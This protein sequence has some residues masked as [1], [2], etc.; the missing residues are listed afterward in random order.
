MKKDFNLKKIFNKFS[1]AVLL[2]AGIAASPTPASDLS[3]PVQ[4]A[5]TCAAFPDFKKPETPM[6][7]ISRD[8][9]PDPVIKEQ[10]TLLRT[11]DLPLGRPDGKPGPGTRHAMREFLLFYGPLYG[12]KDY[13][14]T[15]DEKDATE[16][17]RIVEQA[18]IDSKKYALPVSTMAALRLAAERTNT[19]L[20]KLTSV[21]RDNDGSL[22]GL[23]AAGASNG[24]FRIGHAPWLALVKIYG[25]QYGMEFYVAHI[26]LEKGAHG[27]SPTV[28][29]PFIHR[30]I[31]ALKSNPRLAALL[32]AEYLSQADSFP[33]LAKPPALAFQSKIKEEQNALMTLGFD[34]GGS[35]ADGLRG[36]MT[37]IALRE[38]QLLYG[39]E[40]TPNG[41]LSKEERALLLHSAQQAR[42]DA[43][44]FNVPAA[45]VGAIRMASQKNE[46]DFGY[47]MELAAAESSFSHAIKASSS[48]AT[49]LYQFIEST[50][51][52]T[53]QDYGH[54][55]GLAD[56]STEVDVYM[57]DYGRSQARINNPLL[58]GQVL[59]MRKNP[60][61]SALLST[62]FQIENRG[63]QSCYIEGDLSRTDMYLAHFLGAHDAVYFINVLR[64]D[65]NKSA[66]KIFPEAAEYNISVFYQK[67]GRQ[68]SRERS[69]GEVYNFFSAKFDKGIYDGPA[70]SHPPAVANAPE[71]PAKAKPRIAR[72]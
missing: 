34:I 10:Q 9:A 45:A 27:I 15:L 68:S 47:M 48:S 30:Q 21:I 41:L 56:F 44:R 67:E 53:L 26:T 6:H 19:D 38:F 2:S 36:T 16:L 46:F 66:V 28:A 71:T 13:Q 59:E 7:R 4:P 37:Q 35:T 69:L 8:I 50:W 32:V 5:N 58:R 49:G 40:G 57:D 39:K 60:H 55:Y 29:N 42:E 23:D 12:V 25:A 64:Q 63:R 22:N 61:L 20:D 31:L 54:K 62:D 14:R 3:A 52:H 43:H 18:Q 17:H 51:H 11:L 70:Y 1:A 33:V 24:L 72:K 65:E